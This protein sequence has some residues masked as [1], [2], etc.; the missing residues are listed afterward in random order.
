MCLETL[1]LGIATGPRWLNGPDIGQ[2]ENV[3]NENIL[4]HHGSIPNVVGMKCKQRSL[5]IQYIMTI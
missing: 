5:I 3:K 2:P 4:K 1:P